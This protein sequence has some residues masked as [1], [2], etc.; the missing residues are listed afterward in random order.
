MKKLK[1]SSIIVMMILLLAPL[2]IK[3]EVEEVNEKY[4][5]EYSIDYLL[6]NYN[7]VTFGMNDNLHLDPIRDNLIDVKGNADT[8]IEGP[9]IIN[10]NY[11]NQYIDDLNSHIIYKNDE[12]SF[13]INSPYCVAI[14][15]YPFLV[16]GL[17]GLGGLSAAPKNLDSFC[18]MFVNLVFAVSSQFAGAVAIAGTYSWI[19]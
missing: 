6:R 2:T 10:G 5:G 13:G 7:V 16:D 11:Q 9:I 17:K 4:N 1:L 14:Q 12:S 19:L 3:A 15:S 8:S 18:G